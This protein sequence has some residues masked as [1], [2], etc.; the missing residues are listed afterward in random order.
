MSA[1]PVD[2]FGSNA[3]LKFLSSR[4]AL[5]DLSVFVEFIRQT[6][7]LPTNKIV[8]FGGS[9]PGTLRRDPLA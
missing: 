9:Y 2:K 6:Y 7:N 4:Q 8:T 3:A 5:S 1:C